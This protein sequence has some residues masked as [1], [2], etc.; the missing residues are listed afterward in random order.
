MTTNT[1]EKIVEM[2]K[3]K[4]IPVSRVEKDLGLGNGSLNPKKAS[5][6]KSQRLFKI[7]NYL[8]V[9]FEEFYGMPL[10]PFNEEYEGEDEY[11]F[12]YEPDPDEIKNPATVSDGNKESNYDELS[13]YVLDVMKQL[14]IEGKIRLANSAQSLKEEL[15]AQGSQ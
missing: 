5:D 2:C 3:L 14:P 13:A 1:V 8:G 7:L 15:Q 6:I 12:E 9:T 4:G 10:A 11:E